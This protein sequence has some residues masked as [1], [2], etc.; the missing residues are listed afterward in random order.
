[1]TDQ[2][3]LES[4]LAGLRAQREQLVAL[5]GDDPHSPLIP[6][7]VCTAVPRNTSTSWF[8]TDTNRHHLL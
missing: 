6:L 7:Q 8:A 5:V 3:A 2:G 1:M 4:Q